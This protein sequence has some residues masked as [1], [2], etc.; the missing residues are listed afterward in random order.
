MPN[1]PPRR[2]EKKEFTKELSTKVAAIHKSI[3]EQ[4]A[5]HEMRNNNRISL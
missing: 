4:Q 2:N 3:W 1:L 5:A